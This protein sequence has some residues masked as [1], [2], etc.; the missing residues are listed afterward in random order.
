M[1]ASARR[2]SMAEADRTAGVVADGP[3]PAGLLDA[4]WRYEQAL[5]DDDVTE[6]DALFAPGPLTL[7][8]DAA[9]LLVGHEAISAFRK[10]RGGAPARRV[11]AVHGRAAGEDAAFVVAVV[12]PASGGRGQQTQFW[13][14]DEG[15]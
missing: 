5:R 13:R 4:F 11:L 7:R 2:T 6:L 14:R 15:G 3:V 1:P 12:Q 9:G 8:G 10:G